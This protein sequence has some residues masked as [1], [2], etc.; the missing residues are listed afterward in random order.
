MNYLGENIR[1]FRKKQ[2]LSIKDLA[3]LSKSSS[4]SIS[5][6]ESGKRDPTFR[7][8]LSIAQALE[9]DVAQLVASPESTTYLHNI[10][11]V[12]KFN[13]EEKNAMLIGYSESNTGDFV[14][15]AYLIDFE[16]GEKVIEEIYFSTNNEK[17]TSI[18]FY[19]DRFGPYLRQQR[20][21]I[22]LWNS[23]DFDS[24][25]IDVQRNGISWDTF[26]NFVKKIQDSSFEVLV[27]KK[28]MNHLS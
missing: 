11:F 17:L 2:G 28:K 5:E 10:Q 1:G 25:L 18:E 26:L 4:S 8:I 19:N 7:L 24:G 14:S 21:R 9:I 16:D 20:F 13:S 22:L 3:I 23:I 27:S 6:I 15:W 12:I